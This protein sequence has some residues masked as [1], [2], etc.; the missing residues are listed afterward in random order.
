MPS[1]SPL[2]P[3]LLICFAA[4]VALTTGCSSVTGGYNPT[5]FDYTY[6]PEHI[7][8]Q[9]VKKIVL[10]TTSIGAPPPSYLRKSE[11]RVRSMVKKFLA[12]QGYELLPNYH[13]ENAWKQAT[14][15]YGSVYD[16]S[17]GRVNPN[18]WRSA[19]TKMAEQIRENTDADAI[20]FA[21]LIEHPT[22]HNYTTRNLAR[23][24]GVNRK[25]AIRGTGGVPGD[26]NWNQKVKAASLSVAI[27]TPELKLILNNR[28]GLDTLYELD[29]RK[30]NPKF[31]RRKKLL[32]RDEFVQQG[33]EIAFHPFIEMS[34]YPGIK[35]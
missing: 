13:F 7:A 33:I 17:T 11:T 25:L 8:D 5:T 30:S 23:W 15:S 19:M 24:Y 6:K 16:P 1:I 29:L 32:Q 4:L 26:F 18:A 21:D 2:R 9:P 31:I 12:S 10:A 22:A 3:A 35:E 20:V 34:D 28:G 14:R 27:Y